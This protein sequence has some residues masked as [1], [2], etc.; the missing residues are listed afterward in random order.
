MDRQLAREEMRLA[1]QIADQAARNLRFAKLPPEKKRVA[2]ARD[3]LG[4]LAL[5]KFIAR[6]GAYVDNF[7]PGDNDDTL[8]GGK[9]EVCALGAVYACAT[10]RGLASMRAVQG[11]NAN[12]TTIRGTLGAFFSWEQ[13]GYIEAAFE[14]AAGWAAVE[15]TP[16]NKLSG[17]WTRYDR[18]PRAEEAANWAYHLHDATERMEAIMRNIIRN[19]GT[20]NLDDPA[21]ARL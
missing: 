11:T 14:R 5:K 1:R 4:A 15:G 9:C 16:A 8:D 7:E 19:K 6:T 18:L 13:M 10:D 12:A 20:F 21:P 2:I 3:V 17:S